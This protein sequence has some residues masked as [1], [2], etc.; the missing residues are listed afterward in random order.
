MAIDI[1]KQSSR[2][3]YYYNNT[4]IKCIKPPE[5]ED[6]SWEGLPVSKGQRRKR[7]AITYTITCAFIIV[8]GVIN[9]FIHQAMVSNIYIYI[10][11]YIYYI[12]NRSM[13]LRKHSM[14]TR[15][16]IVGGSIYSQNSL[17]LL[18]LLS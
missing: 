3:G 4:R 16:E 13:Q 11:I 18:S 9:F 14:R 15:V 5:P 10:Y 2:E 17:Q 6:I 8:A 12:Y 7:V 1:I